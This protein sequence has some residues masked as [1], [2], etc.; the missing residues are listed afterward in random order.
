MLKQYKIY[1]L[2]TAP[3]VVLGITLTALA[4]DP[5]TTQVIAD[6]AASTATLNNNIPLM[7]EPAEESFAPTPTPSILPIPTPAEF[8]TG[9]KDIEPA[10]NPTPQLTPPKS[11]PR[12][13]PTPKVV[14]CQSGFDQ[15]FLCLLN[16]YR[17]SKGK[18]SLKLNSKLAAVAFT[19]SS[20][21]NTAQMLSHVGDKSSRFTDR[22]E[23]AGI[24]CS[25]E[26]LALNASS[27]KNL[28]EMWQASGGHNINLLG[29]YTTIGLGISGDYITALFN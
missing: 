14:T 18:G 13:N 26:N 21:M 29:P 7:A 4:K 12:P 27:A 25:A 16:E 28:L 8:K 6:R 5:E 2:L 15:E 19:H 17:A 20:W 11:T 1:L 24:K 23:L 10:A 3:L 9:A 22:C